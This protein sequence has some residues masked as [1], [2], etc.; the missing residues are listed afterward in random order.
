[1]DHPACYVECEPSYA[2]HTQ[3]NEE[4]NKKQKIAD[5]VVYGPPVGLILPDYGAS[6]KKRKSQAPASDLEEKAA[7]AP[8]ECAHVYFGRKRI[9]TVTISI[10]IAMPSCAGP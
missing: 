3:Q 10:E 1:M 9:P 4:Q 7:G 8:P 5:H 6:P 2:P